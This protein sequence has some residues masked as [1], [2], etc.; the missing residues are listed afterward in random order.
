MTGSRWSNSDDEKLVRI[1]VE[2]PI[3]S[4]SEN[5]VNTT[6]FI[7]ELP[8]SN[9]VDDESRALSR[10]LT[11]LDKRGF[12]KPADVERVLNALPINAE[13]G[14]NPRDY[15]ENVP[16][17]PE[18]LENNGFTSNYTQFYRIEPIGIINPSN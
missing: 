2:Y 11:V 4:S 18:Y 5:G 3:E 9:T 12:K 8:Q 13:E 7:A 17:E 10:F 16:L 6:T 14:S 1:E 15:I